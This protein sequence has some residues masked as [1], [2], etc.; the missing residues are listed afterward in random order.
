MAETAVTHD[1][2]E[3]EA[4]AS[5]PVAVNLA[6]TRRLEAERRWPPYDMTKTM[7]NDYRYNGQTMNNFLYAVHQILAA[8]APVYT[9]QYDAPFVNAALE[10]NAPALMAAINVRTV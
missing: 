3:N 4:A 5:K 10:L 8:G 2:A 7:G 9:F 1:M 6:V